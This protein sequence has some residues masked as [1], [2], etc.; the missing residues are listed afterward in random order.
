LHPPDAQK[1]GNCHGCPTAAP[2]ACAPRICRCPNGTIW[3]AATATAVHRAGASVKGKAISETVAG[4]LHQHII[5]P[6]GMEAME[7][8]EDE[9]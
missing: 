6:E 3:S 5:W 1:R 7:I 9:E 4:P 2:I 8:I